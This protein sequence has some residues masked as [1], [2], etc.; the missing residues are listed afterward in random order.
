MTPYRTRHSDMKAQIWHTLSCT[1]LGHMKRYCRLWYWGVMSRYRVMYI[2]DI[3]YLDLTISYTTSWYDIG[4]IPPISRG[5]DI[6]GTP[7]IVSGQQSSWYS[8]PSILDIEDQPFGV[9]QS[10]RQNAS[11]HKWV[12]GGSFVHG[13][14]TRFLQND[15]FKLGAECRFFKRDGC[16]WW[17]GTL[18]TPYQKHLEIVLQHITLTNSSFG[19]DGKFKH[20]KTIMYFGKLWNAWK[21]FAFQKYI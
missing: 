7:D 16:S 5:Q 14:K 17:P 19:M 9:I 18:G 3:V 2:H 1:I 4:G 13:V 21:I 6:G 12:S 20:S 10:S 11:K 8:P 15:V